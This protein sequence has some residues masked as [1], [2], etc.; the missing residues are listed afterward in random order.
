MQNFSEVILFKIFLEK[1]L[2]IGKLYNQVQGNP[3]YRPAMP[4]RGTEILILYEIE[5]RKSKN[6]AN[7][8]YI[9]KGIFLPG[10]KILAFQKYV[11]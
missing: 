5:D 10:C 3:W 1:Q 6:L 11:I 4:V 9:E 7:R 2:I 8:T